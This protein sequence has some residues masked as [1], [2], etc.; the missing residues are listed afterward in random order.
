MSKEDK[1]K[2]RQLKKLGWEPLLTPEEE[3]QANRDF[4]A[5]I[6]KRHELAKAVG[7]LN[8]NNNQSADAP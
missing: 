3:A 6:R 8:Q 5:E 4:L 7:K 1:T 2:I